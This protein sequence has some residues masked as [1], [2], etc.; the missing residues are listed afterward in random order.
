MIVRE[1]LTVLGYRVVNAGLSQY[2]N[3]LAQVAG[4]ATRTGAAVGTALGMISFRVMQV[5]THA[6]AAALSGIVGAGDATIT[7]ANR[8]KNAIT[9]VDD[10]ND[11]MERLYQ[12]ARQTGVELQTTAQTFQRLAPALR[13]TG[14]S[15]SDAIDLI[16]GLQRSLM[17]AGATTTDTHRVLRQLGQA[18]NKGFLNGDEFTSLMENSGALAQRFAQELGK[19]VGQLRE[20]AHKGQLVNRITLPALQRATR[21]LSADFANLEVTAA[22]A[23]DRMSVVVTR[24]IGDFM[25]TFKITEGLGRMTARFALWLENLRK[26]IPAA[27]DFINEMGGMH[28][29]TEFFST[30][31][32][33]GL[34]LAA[35]TA[36]TVVYGLA[37]AVAVLALR[38]LAPAAALAALV[39][40]IDDFRVWTQGGD[41][42]L[43]RQFGAFEEFGA[44]DGPL[45]G[46]MRVLRELTTTGEA[47]VTVLRGF[48]Q[49]L[50]VDIRQGWTTMDS[51]MTQFTS[52]WTGM[53]LAIG[54]A[55]FTIRATA[56]A[57][58]ALRA[59]QL[60]VAGGSAIAGAVTGGAL[61]AGGAATGAGLGAVGTGLLGLLAPAAALGLGVYGI[62]SLEPVTPGDRDR[63]RQ[64][65][66]SRRQGGGFPGLSFA[67]MAG[68]ND[69]SQT[70][71]EQAE[72][73]YGPW[74]SGV[75][76]TSM[77]GP[78]GVSPPGWSGSEDG[79]SVT[80]SN[81]INITI[82]PPAFT[83]EAMTH[84]VEDSMR[85]AAEET[86]SRL[87]RALTSAVPRSE[88][89]PQ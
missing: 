69:P 89:P 35:R 87:S 52:T 56:S 79:S 12:N 51:G 48:Y 70:R 47:A 33:A 55:I 37:R 85:R 62:S 88:A 28:R 4:N 46:F 21:A 64:A 34:I 75:P 32:L 45:S 38:L 2:N 42:L 71:R 49:I 57:L 72:R 66:R 84:A 78:H 43:G 53:I 20:M 74:F 23:W 80:Q 5:I 36:T 13:A 30:V 82:Q 22:M 59:A 50:F 26:G 11:V 76:F 68:P 81:N 17:V 60:A 61:A 3:S 63:A 44:G 18:F 67:D 25:R 7:A 40:L 58:R 41:S 8:I 77:R 54:A 31:A 9:P 10:V 15:T 1:L 24:F 73:I 16:D 19:T 86:I 29:I 6:T 27:R 83:P 14:A 65:E 39:L